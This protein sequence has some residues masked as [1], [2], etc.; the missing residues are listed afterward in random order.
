MNR[1]ERRKLEKKIGKDLKQKQSTSITNNTP[2][3]AR[4][5]PPALA[6]YEIST[7]SDI[8]L[9]KHICYP[10][11]SPVRL[12]VPIDVTR[13]VGRKINN[14]LTVCMLGLPCY[15]CV[16]DY[17]YSDEKTSDIVDDIADYYDSLFRDYFDFDDVDQVLSEE[18]NLV[19][20]EV[21]K[22][23]GITK[24]H[25]DQTFLIVIG[26]AIMTMMDKYGFD[27][28]EL[29]KFTEKLIYRYTLYKRGFITNYEL[30]QLLKKRAGV[31]MVK[32]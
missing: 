22:T 3:F 24:E 6:R 16:H 15:V 20:S 18:A 25:Q 28:T 10:L 19:I 13:G 27:S 12:H 21:A 14:N 31:S 4:Q 11:G 26:T 2:I 5:A 8:A 17:K 1:K 9:N 7:Y 32:E 29:R 23:Q 30:I